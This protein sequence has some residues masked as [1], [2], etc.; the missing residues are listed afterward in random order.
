MPVPIHMVT[1][2]YFFFVRRNPC[3]KV[4]TRTAPVAPSG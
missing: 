4:A 2:P 3:I 1:M